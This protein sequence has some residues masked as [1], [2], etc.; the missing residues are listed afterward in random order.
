MLHRRLLLVLAVAG[1]AI[2]PVRADEG[3][4]ETAS[5][6]FEWGVKIPLR[7]GVELNA[8][9][10][11]PL[12]QSQP[13]PCVFTLTPYIAQ[14]YHDRGMYFGANGYVF[15]GVD[16]RGRGNSAGEFTPLLQEAKD[17]HDVV[18]WL[19]RQPY[20]NGKVTMWGGSY[21]GYNQWA[22]AKEFPPHLATIVPVASPKPGVDY[23]MSHNMFYSYDTQ[24][25][26]LV[27]GRTGQEKIFGDGAFWGTQFRRWY[28][29][30]AP[31]KE[32]DHYVGNPSPHFQ[33]WIA[34]PMQ[35]A[36][37]DSF[38]P[39]REEYAKLALPILSI[40]GQYDG[41]QPGALAFY[42]EH[43]QYGSDAAKATHYLIIGPWD[44]AGTRTPKAEVAGLKFGQAS[45][46]DMNALHKSWYDWTMK[47][48]A[49]PEFLK[50]KVAFYVT[51]EE[52]WR[53]APTLDAVTARHEAWNLDSVASRANDVFASGD[54][55]RDRPGQGK[56]DRYVY[57]PLDTRSAEWEIEE[58]ENALTDQRG[59]MRAD[60]KG[61]FYHTP[62]FAADTDIAGFFKLSAWIELD[63]PDT[64]IAVAVYEVKADGSVVFLAN[65]AVRARYRKSLREATLV[66]PGA[67]ERYDFDRFT[68]VARRIAKGSRLRLAI[69]PVNSMYAEK[70]YNAGGVVA[71]ESGKDARRVTVTLHH[72][73]NRPS[74]L[75]LPIAAAS[76]IASTKK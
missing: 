72:D 65:D 76:S 42:R 44:H 74:V 16:V 23:P 52:A 45:L 6:A 67:I 12:G 7:D 18:E 48:G 11:K 26:T 4:S 53:Y 3:R 43:M 60:G 36:Y 38:S 5:V 21:A 50:D 29:A 61:L 58:Y 8:T 62:A 32:L 37:W 35:D 27:S 33:T 1:C 34:H 15:L 10:Y 49:R 69:G 40:S 68:F 71:E 24:W 63:Q 55:K 59:V 47:N 20:C 9:L 56:P 41:D 73:A 13:L 51:G 64:D 2:V 46:L 19:A 57:D 39:T 14:S 17:G 31:F 70:N 75:S 66:K 25:L 30:Q 54:L 22:S 28:E